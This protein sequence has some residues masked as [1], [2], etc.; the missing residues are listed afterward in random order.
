M[1]F[2]NQLMLLRNPDDIPD[3]EAVGQIGSTATE[4]PDIPT[5]LT[6]RIIHNL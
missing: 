1:L 4:E 5:E 6:K 3:N 2:D